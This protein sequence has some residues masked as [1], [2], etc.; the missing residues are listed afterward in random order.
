MDV[1]T[2]PTSR[3]SAMRRFVLERTDDVSGVSGTGTV[4]EGVV[5]SN[6][7][8]AY[9]WLSPLHTVTMCQSLDVVE[10]LH[11]H[12]GRA[13]IRFIDENK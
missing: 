10:K 13:Q 8:V 11:G 12:D 7:Q 2:V 5:F 6:G 3:A 4:M 1:V 9:A